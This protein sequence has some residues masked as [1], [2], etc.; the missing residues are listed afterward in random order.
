[1]RPTA[2]R[3]LSATLAIAA[4]TLPAA[5]QTCTFTID[6]AQSNFTWGVSTSVGDLTTSPSSF[7]LQGDV[8]L[9]LAG[10]GAPSTGQFAGGDA[11][12]VPD[13]SGFIPN[14]IPFLDPL[15]TVDVT[16]LR[17]GYTS[18]P[19]SIAAGTGAFSQDVVLTAISGTVTTTVFGGAP[20]VSSLA[21]ATGD[22]GLVTGTLT[23][24]GPDL[25][26]SAPVSTVVDASDPMSG[27]TATLTISGTLTAAKPLATVC[28]TSLFAEGSEISLSGGGSQLFT[29]DAGAGRAGD[30]YWMFGSVTGTAPGILFDGGAL[31]PL[32][33]DPYFALTLNTP[34][35]GIFTNFLSLL[36]GSGQGGAAVTVP[37][38]TDPSLVGITLYHAYTTAAVFGAVDFA[39]NAVAVTLVP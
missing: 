32:N 9:E 38:A 18:A 2:L 10:G 34:F 25:V 22:P 39:S 7:Q 1:M 6:Q 35:L 20:E 21:G 30:T 24:S 29:L 27:I 37:A 8:E 4:L 26:L 16:D 19:F 15:V 33:F 17:F 13:L 3:P 36:D 14:P 11:L 31:L 28:G 12:V 5:S 23:V